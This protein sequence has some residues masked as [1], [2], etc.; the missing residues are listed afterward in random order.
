MPPATVRLPP[1]RLPYLMF[2]GQKRDC[3]VAPRDEKEGYG[4]HGPTKAL[5][6]GEK[7]CTGV[8]GSCGAGRCRRPRAD[9]VPER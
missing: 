5:A 2:R 7:D 4:W 1:A 8:P 3:E 6:G 9:G